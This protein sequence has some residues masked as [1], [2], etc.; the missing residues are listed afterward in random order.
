M[1]NYNAKV[2]GK[3]IREYRL[4]KNLTQKELSSR[5]GISAS[6]IGSIESGSLSENGSGSLEVFC[7]IAAALGITLDDIAGDNLEFRQYE[8]K[9]QS[10]TI[11]RIKLEMDSI[12]YNKLLLF[13]KIVSSLLK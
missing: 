7:K 2:V 6:Y 11:N 8:A 12:S 13:K 9:I 5:T 3:N 10:P 1:K 4:A